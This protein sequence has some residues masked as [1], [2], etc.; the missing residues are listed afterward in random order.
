MADVHRFRH[1]DPKRVRSYAV[2]SATV[3][4]VGDLVYQEVD[5]IRPA[6]DL[7]YAASLATAQGTFAKKFKGAAMTASARN[8]FL[9]FLT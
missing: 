1:A 8:P 3:I 9:R 7:T 5:D 4:E 2:N 6:S